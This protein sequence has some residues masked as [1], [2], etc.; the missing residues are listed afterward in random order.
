MTEDELRAVDDSTCPR[1][2]VVVRSEFQFPDERRLGVKKPFAEKQ[3]I[4]FLLE[5]DMGVA[6]KDLY[7]RCGFSKAS[8]CQCRSRSANGDLPKVA[9]SICRIT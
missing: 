5:A 1:L 2:S 3:I 7:R 6:A 9:V 4:G 8:H